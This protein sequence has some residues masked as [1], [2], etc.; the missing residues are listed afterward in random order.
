MDQKIEQESKSEGFS[1]SII[2]VQPVQSQ[3]P[4]AISQEEKCFLGYETNLLG[5]SQQKVHLIK[6][7]KNNVSKTDRFSNLKNAYESHQYDKIHRFTT[8][9][10]EKGKNGELML[11]FKEKNIV[12][13]SRNMILESQI[14]EAGI[15]FAKFSDDIYL[16]NVMNPFN[17]LEG[18]FLG[19]CNLDRKLFVS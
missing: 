7:R 13:S 2:N 15:M 16:L 12:N 14:S 17:L 10:A 6:P 18:F 1:S 19:L 4:L 5:I 3:Q 11:D 9:P 8:R